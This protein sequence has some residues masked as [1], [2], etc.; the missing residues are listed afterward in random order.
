[1]ESKAASEEQKLGFQLLIPYLEKFKEANAGLVVSYVQNE[2]LTMKSL[3]LFPSF[4][5]DSLKFVRPIISLDA[6]HLKS[7]YKG[8]LLAATVLSATNELYPLGFMRYSG[9]E[10]LSRWTGILT[11][12]KEACPRVAT[13]TDDNSYYGEGM[14]PGL[15]FA[16]ISD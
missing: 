5:N 3:C 2:D 13:E 8:T 10:D 11:A 15:K 6:S 7:K 14:V 12:L 1:V 4:M 16:F 9:N